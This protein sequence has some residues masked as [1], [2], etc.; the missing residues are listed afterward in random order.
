MGFGVEGSFFQR[1]RN[2]PENVVDSIRIL[3]RM[4]KPK[5]RLDSGSDK[6][7]PTLFLIILAIIILLFAAFLILRPRASAAVTLQ[8]PSLTSL[9]PSK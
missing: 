5:D 2:P 7:N 3:V 8:K 9:Q 1:S 6:G 4:S